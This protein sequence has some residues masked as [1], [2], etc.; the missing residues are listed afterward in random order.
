ME[1]GLAVRIDFA[2]GHVG[3]GEVLPPGLAAGGRLNATFRE[4]VVDAGSGP[5]R[6]RRAP[7]AVG[8]ELIERYGTRHASRRAQPDADQGHRAPR[9]RLA[10]RRSWYSL[11]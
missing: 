11:S 5:A 3:P 8:R 9:R 6:L 4:P 7:D 1:T 10:E 2:G